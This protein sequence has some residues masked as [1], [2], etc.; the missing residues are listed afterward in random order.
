MVPCP[1]PSFLFSYVFLSVALD[2]ESGQ[3]PRVWTDVQGQ[4]VGWDSFVCW[5]YREHVTEASP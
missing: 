3:S 1:S 2:C 5:D 4:L